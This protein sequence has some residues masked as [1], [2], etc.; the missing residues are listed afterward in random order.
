MPPGVLTG[1]Q[2]WSHVVQVSA[3]DR[4]ARGVALLDPAAG[5]AGAEPAVVAFAV[6]CSAAAAAAL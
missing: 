5:F 1:L 6:A 2:S 4:P 3:S